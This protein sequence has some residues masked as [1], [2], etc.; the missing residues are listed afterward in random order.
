MPIDEV[1]FI[2]A[3]D[4]GVH[5]AC[6]GP[7][8]WTAIEGS[9]SVFINSK[10][11]HRL[12]DHDQHCGGVGAMV[13]G[14]PNVFT[15]DGSSSVPTRA[16]LPSFEGGFQ[17]LNEVTGL[18]MPNMEYRLTTA[19]GKVYK[20]I[21]NEEGFTRVVGTDAAEELKIEVFH[22]NEDEEDEEE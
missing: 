1:Q 13:E 15:G 4:T 18:P 12:D 22:G 14:S 21:T 6:C 19:A 16:V 5:S 8:T 2:N 17:V 11:A 3:V 10:A 7:N 9:S 20:G